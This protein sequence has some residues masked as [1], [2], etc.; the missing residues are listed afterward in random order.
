M[1]EFARTDTSIIGRWWWTV[2][3]W[4]LIALMSMIGFG[5][6]LIFAA[7]PAVAERIGLDSFYFVRHQL[8][9]LVPALC[10]IFC[11]SLLGP[12]D[13][14]RLAT[15]VFLVALVLMA[16]T[17]VTGVEIKGAR[18]WINFPGFSLQPSEFVKPAF[19]VV[20]GWMIAEGRL[21]EEFPGRIIAVGLYLMVIAL[22]LMQPD[23]GMV[24]LTSVAFGAQLFVA[25]MPLLLAGLLIVLGVAGLFGAYFVFPHVASRIDRFLDP[26]A[27]DSYQVNRGLEAF[28]N[29]GLFGR[30]PGEGTV[31]EILPDAHADFI[32]AVAGEELGLI[33]CLVIVA[34]FAFVVM[35]GMSRMLQEGS[36]FVVI[37]VTGLLVQFGLQAI[38]HMSSTLH[39]I[40]TKGM[41]LP[42]ISY[43]G[44]SM[45]GIALCMG[46]TLALTR[47]R[48]GLGEL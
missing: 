31:K 24:V 2:D 41:T 11:I 34:L 13:V 20:A 47:R 30:G 40:P 46:M 8:A 3:R 42:L 25:G 17:L 35:R 48:A 38:I 7:S 21:K 39:L 22:L 16:A 9:C 33:A 37:S 44:S 27:G 18:R 4:T 43:G 23:M 15:I 5:M 45:L 32:F 14:R 12:R 19:A 6:V 26:A 28:M 10:V 29:G 36:L 1:I